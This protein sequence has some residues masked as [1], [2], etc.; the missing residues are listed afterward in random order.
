MTDN[1]TDAAFRRLKHALDHAEAERERLR[2]VDALLNTVN[3]VLAAN[4]AGNDD[5]IFLGPLSQNLTAESYWR[6]CAAIHEA[7][8]LRAPQ[9]K[10]GE[11][12]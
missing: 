5:P 7:L 12:E 4:K 6:L 10:R 2:D 1:E 9:G 3:V 8:P 11:G